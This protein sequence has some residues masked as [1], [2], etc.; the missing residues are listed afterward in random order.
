MTHSV[1][2]L[3]AF[4]IRLIFNV[5]RTIVQITLGIRKM[6]VVKS[7]TRYNMIDVYRNDSLI[8]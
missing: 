3:V 4:K 5:N 1:T 7:T 6:H 8:M 2:C